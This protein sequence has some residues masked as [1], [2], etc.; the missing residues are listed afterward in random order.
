[1]ARGSVVVLTL[2][3]EES[4]VITVVKTTAEKHDF[5]YDFI[6]GDF[7]EIVGNVNNWKILPEIIVAEVPDGVNPI[8]MIKQLG[9]VLPEGEADLIFVWCPK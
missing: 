8:S 1:M 5:S 4:P 2:G 7:E 9:G 3:D 6:H